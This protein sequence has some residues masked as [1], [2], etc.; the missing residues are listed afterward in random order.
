MIYISKIQYFNP[1]LV[2][3]KLSN[4]FNLISF[5][6]MLKFLSKYYFTFGK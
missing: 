2:L 6:I 1:N 5:G 4:F 3:V